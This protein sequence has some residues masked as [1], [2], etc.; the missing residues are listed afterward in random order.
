VSP[1]PTES[2]LSGGRL[3]RHH[4]T[5]ALSTPLASRR[6]WP[7][8]ARRDSA[9]DIPRPPVLCKTGGSLWHAYRRWSA[10]ET[11]SRRRRDEGWL[12]VG[13]DE[14]QG[15]LR[16]VWRRHGPRCDGGLRV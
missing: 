7:P 4:T 16:A 3:A 12:V 5:R 10:E 2:R 8:R 9:Q 15:L 1:Y 6:R 13:R 11:P 14:P